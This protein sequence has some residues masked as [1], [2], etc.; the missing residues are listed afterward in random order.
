M[1]VGTDRPAARGAGLP[2]AGG[3]RVL[4]LL[5]A[6]LAALAVY[7]GPG[8]ADGAWPGPNAA[9]AAADSVAVVS[10]LAGTVERQ[11]GSR[12]VALRVGDPVHTDDDIVTGDDGRVRLRFQD[13]STVVVGPGSSL[14]VAAY[15]YDSGARPGGLLRLAQGILRALV[16]TLPGNA[17]FT[18]NSPTAVAAVRGT[19]FIVEAEAENTAV[20][21][22]DG[23]VLVDS[24]Q[25]DGEA[26]TVRAN[27]GTDVAQGAQPTPPGPWGSPR[28]R[29]VLEL[30]QF[31]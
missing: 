10:R 11:A 20:F 16:D 2:A 6:F 3:L 29:R 17:S 27:E 22:I 7:A 9:Q 15:D 21:V 14:K 13:G 25:P 31:Q 5:L 24:A 19:S 28:I 8:V 4:A 18:V 26:V 1:R 12:R 30:T 23:V